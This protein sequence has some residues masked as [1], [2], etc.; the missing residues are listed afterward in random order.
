MTTPNSFAIFINSPITSAR[1]FYN[2]YTELYLGQQNIGTNA[3]TTSTL[4]AS[5]NTVLGYS[6]NSSNSFFYFNGTAGPTGTGFSGLPSESTLYI[7]YSGSGQ[8]LGGTISEIL[9]YD[10]V[11]TNSE[12]QQVERYLMTKWG[13]QASLPSQSIIANADAF[14]PLQSNTIDYA[15][16]EQIVGSNGTLPFYNILGKNCIYI[17]GSTA[18]FISLPIVNPPVFTFA[19]WFNYVNT[20]YFTMLSYGISGNTTN[21]GLKM[22]I[23]LVSAGSNTVYTALPN[24]WIA[25]GST[26]LGVNTWNFIAITVNQ[27]TYVENVYMNGVFASTATGTGAFTNSPNLLILGKS[28]DNIRSYQGYL[29]NFMYF[30]TI[31]TGA[32]INAIYNQTATD[33]AKASQPRSLS[34]SFANPT[35]SFSWTAG[36]NTTSYVVNFYGVSTNTNVGGLLLTTL[37]TTSTSATYNPGNYAYYYATVIPTN[38]GFLGTI[39]TSSAVVRT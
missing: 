6:L 16:T 17:N 5:S 20:N 25:P 12:R 13:I 10:K 23:D 2:Y 37:T 26:N 31:L 7:G 1:Q 36:A 9:I 30:N 14:L 22:N 39:A 34:L 19:F 33:L 38:S 32:Q 21:S 28:A 29:Q 4:T 27:N 15:K 35:L 8:F 24:Q 11:L 3:V 18:N